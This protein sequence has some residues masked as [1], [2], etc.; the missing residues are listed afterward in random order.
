[1]A[2]DLNQLFKQHPDLGN[3]A[4]WKRVTPKAYKAYLTIVPVDVKVHNKNMSAQ[5][6]VPAKQAIICRPYQDIRIAMN[7]ESYKDS[8]GR[9]GQALLNAHA[10]RSCIN[11]GHEPQSV[12]PWTP[13][14][15]IESASAPVKLAIRL[16]AKKIHNVVIQTACTSK[17][18]G[19]QPVMANNS[20]HAINNGT[21]DYLVADGVLGPN[22]TFIP[23]MNT[24]DIINGRTFTEMFDMRAFA[25][26]NI[27]TG[28]DAH[29]KPAE[30]VEFTQLVKKNAHTLITEF[31][32]KNGISTIIT[33][34]DAKTLMDLNLP[35]DD[36]N[37]P[38]LTEE[39]EHK[40]LRKPVTVDFKSVDG[41]VRLRVTLKTYG[42]VKHIL[43][44]RATRATL[45]S[46]A[47]IQNIAHGNEYMNLESYFASLAKAR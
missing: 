43:S 36:E 28:V 33:E 27:E 40:L 30:L 42:S 4:N 13:V 5:F 2:M 39:S 15:Y 7:L 11:G 41:Q 16:D 35:V 47:N 44:K 20:L 10:K 24:I 18:L 32:K 45:F 9:T 14:M 21:G 25:G 12:L 23:N 31:A 37:L 46:K 38:L 17:Q 8:E 19:G 1:M 6:N 34:D 22:G 26:Q 29:V 3:P